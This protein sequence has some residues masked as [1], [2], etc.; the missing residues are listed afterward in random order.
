MD[1]KYQ[2]PAQGILLTKDFGD[3]KIYHVSCDC[4]EPDDSIL[5]EVSSENTGVTVTHHITS[6]TDYWRTPTKY[7]WLNAFLN[8]IKLTKDIWFKGQ[9]EYQTSTMLTEQQ[10]YNFAETLRT[11]IKDVGEFTSKR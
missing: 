2:K 6:K 9:I 7:Y 8:R 3:C 1:L 4:G 10:A 5:V 11:A